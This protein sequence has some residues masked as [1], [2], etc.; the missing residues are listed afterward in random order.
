MSEEIWLPV[1]G[2]K[3]QYHVSNRGRVKSIARFKSGRWQEDLILKGQVN[4]K[5]YHVVVLCYGSS[6]TTKLVHRLVAEAFIPKVRGKKQVNHIDNNPLNNN[7]WNLEWTT[8]KENIQHAAKQGRLYTKRTK[9]WVEKVREKM[10]TRKPILVY[11]DDEFICEAM[12]LR[13]AADKTG[14]DYRNISAA[15]KGRLKTTG[16]Y[17][18]EYK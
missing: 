18:F 14:A 4:N 13:D 2:F 15:C 6:R 17:R 10:K 12:S 8:Q 9:E 11:K 3:R 16:G 5:G 7:D 1:K